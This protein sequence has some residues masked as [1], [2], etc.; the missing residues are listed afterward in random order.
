LRMFEVYFQA[1]KFLYTK[2]ILRGSLV[3]YDLTNKT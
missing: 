1:K 2:E 3:P